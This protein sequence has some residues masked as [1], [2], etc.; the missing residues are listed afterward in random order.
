MWLAGIIIGS[1]IGLALGAAVLSSACSLVR[2]Q[3]PDFFFG[4]VICFFVGMTL[5]MV[6]CAAGIAGTLGAGVSLMSLQTAS[7]F[8]RLMARGAPVGL[9][10]TPFLSAGIYTVVLRDC[11]YRRALLVWAAQF[12]VIAIFLVVIWALLHGLGLTTRH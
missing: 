4:M 9:L 3:P 2:V 6:Q 5:L 7:D 10:S 12:V 1:L 11:S 8:Q